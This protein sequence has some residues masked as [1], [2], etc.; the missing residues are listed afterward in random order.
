MTRAAV[1]LSPAPAGGK[2][3]RPT[4]KRKRA[5]GYAQPR[6]AEERHSGRAQPYV[7][8]ARRANASGPGSHTPARKPVRGAH[9]KK[10]QK[11]GARVLDLVPGKG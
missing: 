4:R 3:P 10:R 7:T 2:R 5:G 1:T 8:F 11:R 9:R 6:P